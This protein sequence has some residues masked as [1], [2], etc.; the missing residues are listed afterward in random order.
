[1]ELWICNGQDSQK[2]KVSSNYN[3]LKS[4]IPDDFVILEEH[5]WCHPDSVAWFEDENC[6]VEEPNC[7]DVYW[8][9]L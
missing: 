4:E 5:S 9:K 1:M 2:L 6:I 7:C 3:S 8:I